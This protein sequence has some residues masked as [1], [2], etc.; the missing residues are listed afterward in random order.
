[1]RELAEA[2]AAERAAADEA[3]TQRMAELEARMNRERSEMQARLMAAEE[4]FAE[5][6]REKR[7]AAEQIERLAEQVA[8]GFVSCSLS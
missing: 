8:A 4:R 3:S 7:V 5:S 6:E 2:E 1:M